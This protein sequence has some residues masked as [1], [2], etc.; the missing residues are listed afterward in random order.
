MERVEILKALAHPTR[1]YIMETLSGVGMEKCVCELVEELPFAQSTISKHL[2]ILRRA[3][4]VQT[5]KEGL[6][7]FYQLAHP[8][9][10]VF[11]G[12]LLQLEEKLQEART[13]WR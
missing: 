6:K 9:L 3:G 10:K 11:L 7:V 2:T 12:D 1:L 13:G 8:E 4:L 5:R